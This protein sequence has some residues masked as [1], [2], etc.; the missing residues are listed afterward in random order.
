[1]NLAHPVRLQRSGP[2]ANAVRQRCSRANSELACRTSFAGRCWSSSTILFTMKEASRAARGTPARD[3]SDAEVSDAAGGRAAP[4]SAACESITKCV[5]SRHPDFQRVLFPSTPARATHRGCALRPFPNEDAS[6]AYYALTPPNGK[7]ILPQI[8]GDAD[9]S[10]SSSSRSTVPPCR[11]RHGAVP[12]KI[13]GHY[14]CSLPGRRN[15][16]IMFSDN[17]H[18]WRSQGCSR[19]RSR[20]NSSNGN[21]GSPIETKPAGWC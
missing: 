5:F 16:L 4:A 20:G 17:I 2:G 1:M 21:C 15:I 8:A 11:T 10:I 13:N 7:I 9:F 12:R 18:F 6:F 19:P 14:S 3:A